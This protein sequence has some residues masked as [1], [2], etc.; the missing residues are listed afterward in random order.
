DG[1]NLLPLKPK[2]FLENGFM[3]SSNQSPPKMVYEKCA[4][5]VLNVGA[6][7]FLTTGVDWCA[8]LVVS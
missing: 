8:L 6:L 2:P 1:E 5:Y 4:P 7:W 3:Y